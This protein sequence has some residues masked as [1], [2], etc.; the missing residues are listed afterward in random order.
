MVFTAIIRI[1]A[2]RIGDQETDVVWE[3]FWQM[4]ENCLAVAMVSLSAFRSVFVGHNVQAQQVRN[5]S[6]YV[7]KENKRNAHDRKNWMDIESEEAKTLPEIPR[8]TMTGVRTFIRG[9]T[10]PEESTMSTTAPAESHDQS[11]SHLGGSLNKIRVD[12]SISQET[13]EV[14]DMLLHMY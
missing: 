9:P 3:C 1:S 14:R 5:K 8:A 7:L 10:R 11:T 12:H 6:W 2:I 4:V 13:D